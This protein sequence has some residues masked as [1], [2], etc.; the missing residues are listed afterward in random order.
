MV[1]ILSVIVVMYHVDC[2]VNIEPHWCP[3]KKTHLIVVYD[4]FFFRYHWIQFANILVGDFCI[5]VHQECRSAVLL[6]WC[7]YL[8]LESG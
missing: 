4:F 6:L 2:F 1:F 3:G 8:I 5:Y 7:L